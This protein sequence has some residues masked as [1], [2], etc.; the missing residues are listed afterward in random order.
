MATPC[1]F[2]GKVLE[3]EGR[4]SEVHADVRWLRQEAEKRNGILD[5]HI[6]DSD[7]YRKRIDKNGVWLSA[8]RWGFVIMLGILVKVLW[9]TARG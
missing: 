9:T 7:C 3:F 1:K 5:E 6:R 8:L 2:E 4:L